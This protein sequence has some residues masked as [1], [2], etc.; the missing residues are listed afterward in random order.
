MRPLAVALLLSLLVAGCGKKPPYEGRSVAELERM[1][2]DPD[3][4][5]Q[6]QGAFGLGR[7][8]AEAAPAVPALARSLRSPEVLVRQ[9]AALALGEIGAAG[10]AVPALAGALSD[11]E[12]SVRRQA[13]VALGQIGPAAVAAEPDLRRCRRDPHTLVRKAAEEA[14]ARISGTDSAKSR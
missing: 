13:A 3:P 9:Q 4:Q 11:S 10:E 5:V 1:L 14:I 12:W 6:A 8:G 2:D 7:H